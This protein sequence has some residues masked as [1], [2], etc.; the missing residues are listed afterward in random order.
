MVNLDRAPG[1]CVAPADDAAQ[2]AN[3]RHPPAPGGA[4]SASSRGFDLALRQHAELP[5]LLLVRVRLNSER[6]PDRP[7]LLRLD[8]EVVHLHVREDDLRL[9]PGDRD[10]D[11]GTGHLLAPLEGRSEAEHPQVRLVVRVVVLADVGEVSLPRGVVVVE[12]RLQRRVELDQDVVREVHLELE[13]PSRLALV[14]VELRPRVEIGEQHLRL[15]E[16]QLHVLLP[17]WLCFGFRL[18]GMTT[19]FSALH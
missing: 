5:A 16:R 14:A 7:A 11:P 17:S 15:L 8:R 12:Q 10:R 4:H 1:L 18:S 19:P 2:A 13:I 9:R 6:E 3:R